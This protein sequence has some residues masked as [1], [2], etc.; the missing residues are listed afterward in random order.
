MKTK[1]VNRFE[2]VLSIF[3]LMIGRLVGSGAEP[4]NQMPSEEEIYNEA[5]PKMIWGDTTNFLRGQDNGS[6]LQTAMRSGINVSDGIIVLT[7]QPLEVLH[8]ARF[9]TEDCLGP[10]F[11]TPTRYDHGIPVTIVNPTNVVY[12]LLPPLNER[13][14]MEMTN[15]DGAPVPKTREGRRLGKPASH[16]SLTGVIPG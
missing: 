5:N 9:C 4:T 11:Y 16:I 3:L 1:F 13:F 7:R 2:F 8:P 10:L 6:P 12:T 15:A 14:D